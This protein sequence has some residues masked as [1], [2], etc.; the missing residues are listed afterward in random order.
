MVQHAAIDPSKAPYPVLI[1][2]H[3]LGGTRTTYSVLC[4]EL[5]SQVWLWLLCS[6]AS[7][8]SY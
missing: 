6:P 1:F 8:C 3:G 5:A 7:S 4:R 2:S